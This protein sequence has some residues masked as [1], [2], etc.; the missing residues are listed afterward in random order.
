MKWKGVI[1]RGKEA[2]KEDM[3]TLDHTHATCTLREQVVF[4]R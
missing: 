1:A 3:S 4:C 2:F